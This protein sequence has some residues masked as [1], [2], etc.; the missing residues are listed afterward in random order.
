MRIAIVFGYC[1]TA[2]VVFVSSASGE[3]GREVGDIPERLR[4]S[5]KLDPFY[6]KYASAGGL[7]VLGSAKVSDA[8]LDEAATLIDHMLAGRDDI[9]QAM[10]KRKVR[11]VVMAPDEMTTDGP[12]QRDMQPKEYWDARARGLGGRVC[13]CGEENLLNLPGDRYAVENILIHEFSHTIHNFG[14]KSVD[15][16]FDDRLKQ[17]FDK[18]LAVGRWEKTYAATNRE[19]YFAEGVQDY[20]DCNATS[21]REGVHN[22]V[23]TR[24]E[25][26]AYDPDLYALIDEVFRQN[27]WR[28]VRYDARHPA[29]TDKKAQ[30]AT[31]TSP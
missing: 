29:A 22:D 6:A 10:I 25:L 19:E 12:E 8:A 5:L 17:T 21:P 3:V 18:S 23:N 7:P 31:A 13:S 14:L 11:F 4:A 16:E 28:Y 26:R 27:P 2:A 24:D 9:R 15:P 1:V 20:F 30:D